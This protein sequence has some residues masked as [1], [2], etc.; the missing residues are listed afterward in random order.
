MPVDLLKKR[1]A[2]ALEYYRNVYMFQGYDITSPI[3]CGMDEDT[4]IHMAAYDGRVD[5]IN[6]MLPFIENI[7]I[8]GDIGNTPLHY[9][10]M[11]NNVAAAKLLLEHGADIMRKNDY[12]D[13]PLEWMEINPAFKELIEKLSNK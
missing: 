6:D 11:Q 10:V 8:P 4:P 7:N 9:A 2:T 12:D 13:T 3:S 1:L 5:F